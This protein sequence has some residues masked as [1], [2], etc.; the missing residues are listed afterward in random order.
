MIITVAM[1]TYFLPQFSSLKKNEL[2]RLEILKGLKYIIPS[3]ILISIIV[4]GFRINI[5]KILFSEK[6]V[7]AEILFSGQLVGDC[8][9]IAN[10]ILGYLMIAKAMTKSF[11]IMEIVFSITLIFFTYLSLENWGL[12]AVT[13]AYAL[14]N[15]LSFIVL[16]IIFRKIIFPK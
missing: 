16:T 6:F 12:N 7:P 11:I 15:L 14:N 9:K 3:V 8:F 4:Y 10:W 1:S 5:L 2:I 13:W